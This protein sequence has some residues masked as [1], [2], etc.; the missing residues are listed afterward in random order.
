MLYTKVFI[1]LFLC[2]LLFA[3]A[4]IL[5]AYTALRLFF[6]HISLV[7]LG[8]STPFEPHEAV[9]FWMCIAGIIASFIIHP[10]GAYL[11]KADIR[12]LTSSAMLQTTIFVVFASFQLTLLGLAYGAFA[13]KNHIAKQHRLN[14]ARAHQRVVARL[15]NAKVDV[16]A[17]DAKVISDDGKFV[18]AEVTLQI[19]N[20]PFSIP[21]YEMN[22]HDIGSEGLFFTAFV[23][24]TNQSIKN[25]ALKVF[26]RDNKWI[27]YDIFTKQETSDNSDNIVLRFEFSRVKATRNEM[28]NTITPRLGIWARDDEVYLNDYLFF[29]KPISVSFEKPYNYSNG[30]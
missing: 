16:V 10:Y 7:G 12:Q 14:L 23:R 22:I 2:S 28:P 26:N 8:G 20:V 25:P 15:D 17:K 11:I 30:Q 24:E 27:F 21:Y 18:L 9:I 29:Y 4:F 3:G 5:C 1:A 13:T 19:K 6:G